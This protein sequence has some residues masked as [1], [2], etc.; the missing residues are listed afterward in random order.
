MP[1]VVSKIQ[2]Q[3]EGG[4]VKKNVVIIVAAGRGRRAGAGLPKQYRMIAGKSLLRWTIEAIYRCDH[5]AAI[6]VVIHKGDA[7]QFK[8]ATDGLDLPPPVFGGASR[9]ASVLSGLKA[10]EPLDPDFVL[11]HDA[12][13]PFISGTV[14]NDVL[15]KLGSGAEA[16]VPALAIVDTLKIAAEGKIKRAVDRDSLYAIQTPQGFAFQPLKAA[17]EKAQGQDYTD[18]GS[19][20]EAAGYS[21][22]ISTGDAENFKVTH[23]TDF[24]KAE[25]KIMSKATDVRVGTGYDVHRFEEGNHIWLCGLSVPFTKGL[26]GHSDAD[27]ALHA[28]TDA[29]F[30]SVA[31]GDIGIHFPPSEAQWR[32]APSEIFLKKAAAVIREKGGI[33]SHVAVCIVCELPKIGPYK[34]AMRARI[35][36]MLA[37]SIERVSVQATTTEKLGFTG[38]G[39]GIAAEATAT[40]RLPF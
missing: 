11:I 20:M 25:A 38:R 8:A 19:V 24:A 26:K 37:I 23:A 2:S 13:R 12:A 6:Q 18:D 27:V 17:H 22:S 40:V 9:Q 33:V 15:A 5:N 34:D 3:N 35:A 16:V 36:D 29:L 28:L 7:Q 14:Y 31:A 30:A 1:D 32:G 39:E 4:L 21:V 10:V